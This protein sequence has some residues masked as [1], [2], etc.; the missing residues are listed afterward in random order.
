LSLKV[1]GIGHYK[2]ACIKVV[3]AHIFVNKWIDLRQTKTK[4]TVG[5]YRRMHFNSENASFL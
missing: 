2:L 1:K 5:P 4:M 3:I